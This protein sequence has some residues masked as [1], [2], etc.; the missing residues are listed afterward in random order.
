M[1]PTLQ[2]FQA[3][4]VPAD[5]AGTLT[6]ANDTDPREADLDGVTTIVLQFPKFTDGRA[7]SQAFLLRRRLGFT[8]EIRATGDVLIDQLAQMQRSGFSQAVLRNDQSLDHGRKLLAHYPAF[9]QGDA[10]H[11]QPHFAVV[12]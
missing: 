5:D 2:L 12:A 6:L 8:G 3:E 7:F 10:V 1:K 4:A 11:T 9:Y